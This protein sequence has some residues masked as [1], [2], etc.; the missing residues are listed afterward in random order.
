MRYSEL[1]EDSSLLKL[2]D[3]IKD[4][5]TPLASSGLQYITMDQLIKRVQNIPS[6]LLVDRQLLMN[7]INPRSFPLVKSIGGDK[8]FF[9]DQIKDQVIDKANKNDNKISKDAT[10][11]AIKQ[12]TK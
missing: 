1:M 11:Q 2:S 12:V 6:G 3:S 9:T 5:L 8:I 7:I 4:I 10:D